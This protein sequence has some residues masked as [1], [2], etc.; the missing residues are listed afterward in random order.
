MPFE[1][2]WGAM[3][4]V[5]AKNYRIVIPPGDY[6]PHLQ[7]QKTDDSEWEDVVCYDDG[8]GWCGDKWR[9]AA[10][11][12]IG[13]MAHWGVENLRNIGKFLRGETVSPKVI[14]SI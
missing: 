4:P 13:S 3:G 10:W 2:E 5:G 7:A 8:Y 1:E 12:P 9:P 14:E 6:R 11:R